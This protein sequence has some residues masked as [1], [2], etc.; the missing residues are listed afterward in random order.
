MPI[1]TLKRLILMQR[2]IIV[3]KLWLLTYDLSIFHSVDNA[4][5]Y[6]HRSVEMDKSADRIFSKTLPEHLK[7]S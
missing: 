6:T 5:R 7:D 2:K 4:Q 3:I 1:N